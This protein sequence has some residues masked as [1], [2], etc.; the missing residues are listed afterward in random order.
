MQTLSIHHLSQDMR[1]LEGI[2]YVFTLF[3]FSHHQSFQRG[4]FHAATQAVYS[5]GFLQT[6]SHLPKP[7]CCSRHVFVA[8]PRSEISLVSL[9]YAATSLRFAQPSVDF[10]PSNHNYFLKQVQHSS[11]MITNISDVEGLDRWSSKKSKPK[12]GKE[13]AVLLKC[14]LPLVQSPLLIF[15]CQIRK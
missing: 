11:S 12:W 1:W 10:H 8:P 15:Q 9:K 3:A 13:S 6:Q 2:N 5:G 4:D 7:L 14:M